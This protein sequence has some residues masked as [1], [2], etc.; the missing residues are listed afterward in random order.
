MP[1][2]L[3]RAI[4]S[5]LEIGFR[6][7]NTETKQIQGQTQSMTQYTVYIVKEVPL[8]FGSFLQ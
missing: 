2:Q 4:F 7:H 1:E 3:E 5:A 6:L 8:D